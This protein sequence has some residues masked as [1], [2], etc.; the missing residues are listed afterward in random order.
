M[1]RKI[2]LLPKCDCHNHYLELFNS[3][4]G[5]NIL[6][7]RYCYKCNR[8]WVDTVQIAHNSVTHHKNSAS[9]TKTSI[10]T[11]KYVSYL[12]MLDNNAINSGDLYYIYDTGRI[13]VNNGKELVLLSG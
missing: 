13:Y 8:H 5:E 12:N 10:H 9:H 6:Y 11:I 2:K 1:K 4:K 7:E 3:F